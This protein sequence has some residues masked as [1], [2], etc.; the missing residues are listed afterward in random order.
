MPHHKIGERVA[1]FESGIVQQTAPGTICIPVWNPSA[2]S[3]ASY[4]ALGSVPATAIFNGVQISNIGTASLYINQGSVNSTQ[5]TC[6]VLLAPGASLILPAYSGTVGTGGTIWANTGTV[7]YTGAAIA[8]MP[9]V[10]SVV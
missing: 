4:G 1:L 6:G 9:S 8:G 10:L 3:T 2:S 5:G 7:G